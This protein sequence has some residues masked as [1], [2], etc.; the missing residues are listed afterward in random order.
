MKTSI[1]VPEDEVGK[2]SEKIEQ[3][4]NRKTRDQSIKYNIQIIGVP[5]KEEKNRGANHQQSN[6]KTNF[7]K[8]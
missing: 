1:E 8:I 2:I 4:E 6:F 5:H 3:R 7:L